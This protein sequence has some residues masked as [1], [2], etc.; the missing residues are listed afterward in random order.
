MNKKIKI[1]YFPFKLEKII[2]KKVISYS[3]YNKLTLV[4]INKLKK[5]QKI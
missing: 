1:D 3:N 5:L 4:Q 2:K